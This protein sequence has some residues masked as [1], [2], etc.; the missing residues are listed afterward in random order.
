VTDRR[1]T[2]R[3]G[4]PSPDRG[5]ICSH[6][7]LDQVFRLKFGAPESAGWRPRGSYRFGYF[8]PDEYYEALVSRLVEPGAAWL[9]VGGGRHLF[10]QNPALAQLLRERSGHVVGV[11]PDDTLGENRF[12]HEKAQ[13]PIE[14]FHSR[15]AFPLVTLRMVAEHLTQPARVMEALARLTERHGKVVVYTVNRWSPA[16]VAS[17]LVPF[18]FH[19]AIKHM[20]WKSEE[21]DTFPVAYQ[22]NTRRCLERH[23]RA[24]GFRER[25]FAYLDD[26][27]VFAR[28]R[29]LH[30]CELCAWRLLKAFGLNYPENCLLGV[31][32]LV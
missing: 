11:D 4:H 10:P 21:R 7:D 14:E 6:D 19:H 1:A 23:F 15:R 5:C 2:D 27:R 16:S 9:D 32:E 12:V 8:T 30:G 22:L 28:F 18:R 26:C 25:H 3:E 29:T 20:L 13:C 24:G 17:W 31:Y